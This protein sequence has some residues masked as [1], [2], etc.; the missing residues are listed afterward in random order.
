MHCVKSVRIC[1]IPGPYIP[2]FR[3]NT[4]GYGVSLLIQLKCGK[5]R[6]RKT[7]NTDTF[8]AVT[9]S[10]TRF[11]RFQEGVGEEAPFDKISCL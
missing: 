8:H 11:P 10:L 4:E 9:S 5:I 7:P 2:A 6:T 1:R 3:L